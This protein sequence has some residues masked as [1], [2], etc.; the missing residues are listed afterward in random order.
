M[1]ATPSVRIRPAT[2][3]DYDDAQ[4]LYREC[5]PGCAP[6]AIE[7]DH[8]LVGVDPAGEV[9]A[10]AG[11]KPSTLLAGWAHHSCAGVAPA[12]RGAGLQA[13]LVRAR[14]R[15]AKRE[16]F[17]H[18]YTYTIENPPSCNTLIRCGYRVMDPDARFI[19]GTR[20]YVPGA[21]YWWRA[22]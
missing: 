5:L 8:A 6:W 10:F 13:R 7:A 11:V 15:W 14:E 4:E 22:L 12:Y 18:I 1:P 16:G 3:D 21:V 19:R 9:V 20:W 2:P 17:T